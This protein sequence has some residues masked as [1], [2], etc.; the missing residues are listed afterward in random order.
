MPNGSS[1]TTNLR[2]VDGKRLLGQDGKETDVEVFDLSV[3]GSK[4]SFVKHG[5]TPTPSDYLMYVTPAAKAAW[6]L[7]AKYTSSNAGK[8][9]PGRSLVLGSP[10]I[11]KSRSA[12]YLLRQLL[13]ADK[14]YS[15]IVYEPRV[16]DT[17]YKWTKTGRI[18]AVHRN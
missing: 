16:G 10:G 11:I 5:R 18:D 6:D 7:V 15:E 8:A 12:F 2:T 1:W 9:A 4:G 14:R 17:A 13:N 3:N